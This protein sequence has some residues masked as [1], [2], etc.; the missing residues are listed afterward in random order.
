MPLALAHSQ[1][2][3]Y[4]GGVAVGPDALAAGEDGHDHAAGDG[5]LRAERVRRRAGHEAGLIGVFDVAIE[6][7]GGGH[8]RERQVLC[9][10]GED[11]DEGVVGNL[12]I[13]LIYG[14]AAGASDIIRCS[15]RFFVAC[16][17]LRD[18]RCGRAVCD[19]DTGAFAAPIFVHYIVFDR[20]TGHGKCA[21]D[22]DTAA[23]AATT[24]IAI[25]NGA[26]GHLKHA[27]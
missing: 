18:E 24:C 9:E 15:V 2:A 4:Q 8:V 13:R 7:V 17:I 21:A 10:R 11:G 1:P 16:D 26:A 3:A 19:V 22:I 14:I 27:A 5:G 25:F 23:L 6:P 20:A 12:G